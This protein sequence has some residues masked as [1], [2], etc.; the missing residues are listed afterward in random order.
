[1]VYCRS[2]RRSARA[3]EILS[4]KGFK[5]LNLLGGMLEWRELQGELNRR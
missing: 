5:V 3:C 1:M 2:G 4:R